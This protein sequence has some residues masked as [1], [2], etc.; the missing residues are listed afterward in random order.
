MQFSSQLSNHSNLTNLRSAV[1]DSMSGNNIFIYNQPLHYFF[2]LFVIA[3]LSRLILI[4]LNHQIYSVFVFD[5]FK[6]IQHFWNDVQI[7]VQENS[8]ATYT[9]LF[10][11]PRGLQK[12]IW[13]ILI[14]ILYIVDV[15][16]LALVL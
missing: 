11:I 4:D 15:L 3:A 12:C 8:I 10:L 6:Q 13:I 14:I 7:R 5:G 2:S 1:H 9:D 16:I